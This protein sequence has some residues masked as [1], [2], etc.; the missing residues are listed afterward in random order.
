MRAMTQTTAGERVATRGCP[1]LAVLKALNGL[2]DFSAHERETMEGG[3]ACPGADIPVA[4]HAADSTFRRCPPPIFFRDPAPLRDRSL[5]ELAR[6]R[7]A[8]RR[9]LAL[10]EAGVVLMIALAVAG[11]VLL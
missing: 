5:R 8:P 7:P 10:E 2:R 6:R 9:A 3:D 1:P 4:S 11:A